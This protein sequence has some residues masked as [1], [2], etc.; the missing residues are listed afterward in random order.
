MKLLHRTRIDVRWRDLDAFNHVNNSVYLTFIEE[1]RIR[2]MQTLGDV[3]NIAGA[4]PVVANTN[5]NYRRQLDWPASLE[6]SLHVARVGNSSLTLAHRIVAAQD[7]ETLYSD[8]ETVMV[9][10]DPASGRPV[11]LPEAVRAACRS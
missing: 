4:A 7:P 5:V 9:W 6:V 11:P 2:W 10:I 8:G 1:A 3:W